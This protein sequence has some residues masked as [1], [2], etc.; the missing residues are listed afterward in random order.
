MEFEWDSNKAEINLKKHGIDFNFAVA[1]FLDPFAMTFEDMDS[2]AEQR[3]KTIGLA[4]GVAVLLVV[5]TYPNDQ[6]IRIISARKLTKVEKRKY[7]YS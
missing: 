7:G 2:V 3:W 5:H 6:C 1:V 4:H